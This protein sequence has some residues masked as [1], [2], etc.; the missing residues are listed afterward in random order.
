MT[1]ADLTPLASIGG[2]SS[3][4]EAQSPRIAPQQFAIQVIR[5]LAHPTGA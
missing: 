5:A 1:R 3:E 4:C 2:R